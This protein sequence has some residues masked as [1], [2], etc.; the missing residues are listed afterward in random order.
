MH[1]T[2]RAPELSATRKRDSC[3]ITTT[4]FAGDSSCTLENFD[5]SP[6]LQ[7]RKRARLA[8]ADP[9]TLAHVVRLVVRVEVL[10][11]LHRLLVAAV[12]HPVDDRDHDGLVHL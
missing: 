1:S 5:H 8:H 2:S 9:V 4:T 11:A 3:W 12:P 7:L 10:R 6:P